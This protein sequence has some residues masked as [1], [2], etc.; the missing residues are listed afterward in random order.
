MTT[1]H[2]SVELLGDYLDGL[3]SDAERRAAA[4]HVA[5][6]AE[7]ARR[8]AALERLRAQAAAAPRAVE[9]PEDLWPAIHAAIAARPTVAMLRARAAWWRRAPALAAAALLIAVASSLATWQVARVRGRAVAAAP[10]SVAAAPAAR[11][12]AHGDASGRSALLRYAALERDY[13]RSAAEL[14]ATLDALRADL[15]A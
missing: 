13:D 6:C 10:P 9:P 3:L 1:T 8:L 15:G 14:R 5:G 4:A 12:E 2:T 7:C 11:D